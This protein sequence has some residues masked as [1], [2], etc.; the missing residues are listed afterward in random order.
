MRIQNH[1]ETFVQINFNEK[2]F[3]ERFP[4]YDSLDKTVK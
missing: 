4:F 1:I 2:V 3:I